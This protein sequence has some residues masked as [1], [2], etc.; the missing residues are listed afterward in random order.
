LRLEEMQTV[1][2]C[3]R[4][5]PKNDKERERDDDDDYLSHTDNTIIAN[6]SKGHKSVYSFS[7]I[8]TE[9]STNQDV[10]DTVMKPLLDAAF[11]GV[12]GCLLAYG[13]TGSG[14]TY[15]VLGPEGLAT[16]G[17]HRGLLPRAL[18]DIFFR[19]AQLDKAETLE[20]RIGALEIYQNKVFDLLKNKKVTLVSAFDN[21][22]ISG[23]AQIKVT[24]A[25]EAKAAIQGGINIRR[26]AATD[27]NKN[28]SRSHFVTL[29]TIVRYN[30]E[31]ATFRASQ[32]YIVDLAGS[33]RAT[34]T[35]TNGERLAEAG[36]INQSLLTLGICIDKIL[37]NKRHVPFRDSNLTRLLQNSLGGSS[38]CSVIVNISPAQYNE[39]ETLNT[40]RFGARTQKIQNFPTV[41]AQRT[42]GE[43]KKLLAKHMRAVSDNRKTLANLDDE[44]AELEALFRMAKIRRSSLRDLRDT[45]DESK[46]KEDG[47]Q[48]R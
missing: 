24:N 25:T 13:Q 40:L 10:Y 44:L 20:V 2:V 34:K 11:E 37:E 3:A 29:L 21:T 7:S 42:P 19:A 41:N 46:E 30:S 33:E 5:R 15:T 38:L 39:S 8:M 9:E 27:M 17:E 48:K 28:S 1:K 4:I 16:E 18:D 43:L 35:G 12:N 36:K 32:L 14:K 45:V 31:T 6:T 47:E 26:T 23:A 22:I